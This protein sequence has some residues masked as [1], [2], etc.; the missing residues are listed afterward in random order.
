MVL[1]LV[2]GYWG[3]SFTTHKGMTGCDGTGS[4]GGLK[5]WCLAGLFC[6]ICGGTLSFCRTGSGLLSVFG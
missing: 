2:C 5:V 1:S 4:T 3:V 6:R